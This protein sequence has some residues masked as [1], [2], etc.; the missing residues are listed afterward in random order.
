MSNTTHQQTTGDLL[1]QACEWA[2]RLRGERL[3]DS[4]LEQ[5]SD[6]L[7]R[8]H[9]HRQAFEQVAD[10]WGEVGVLPTAAVDALMP[11]ARATQRPSLLGRW[12]SWRGGIAGVAAVIAVVA[13][14]Y[15]LLP[16]ATVLDT[17][18][19]AKGEQREIALADGSYVD[20]NTNTLL[21]VRLGDA[22]RSLRLV[23][24]EAYFS[25]ASD[26]QRPFVVDLDGVTAQALG[27]EFNVFR[28]DSGS[29]E[30]T[31]TEGVVQVADAARPS[32][33]TILRQDEAV[34]YNSR[35]G[36]SPVKAADAGVTAWR[37]RQ[38][39]F[40]STP[41]S[42]VISTLNRYSET[43][44]RLISKDAALFEVSGVFSTEHPL[45]TAQAVAE[46][47]ALEARV[48]SDALQLYKTGDSI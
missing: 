45:E 29:A 34:D 39:V 43:P 40:A 30:V 25:V 11:Q 8:D 27:T 2:V 14:V 1:D 31:V 48:E 4:I 10:M 16:A 42:E 24:G 5:F 18:R 46:A 17:Y 38:M 28:P 32:D 22:K 33:V 26:Q 9:S 13:V 35:Q 3:D 21:E 20:L 15:L 41:L 6:W 44:I 12:L 37:Q 19:T 47:L 36:I 23:Q 7:S